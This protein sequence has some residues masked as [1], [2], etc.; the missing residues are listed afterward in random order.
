MKSFAATAALPWPVEGEKQAA[1]NE[2]ERMYNKIGITTVREG[3]C[4]IKCFHSMV[5]P[6]ATRPAYAQPRS[7]KTNQLQRGA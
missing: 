7:A 3:S 5:F 6:N 1:W 4:D 2:F